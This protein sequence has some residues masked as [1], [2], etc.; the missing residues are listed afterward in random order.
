M[1]MKHRNLLW[2][3]YRIAVI[4]YRKN[5]KD[6]WPAE[7][8]QSVDTTVLD[9]PVTMHICEKSTELGGYTFREIRHL[10]K[11]GHQ[12]A[13]IAT[14]FHL[15]KAIIAGAAGARKTSSVTLYRITISIR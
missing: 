2:E 10:A 5:V 9:Q 8:F 12:T 7:D 6:K 13:I 3:E 11:D 14:H 4:T 15:D 1:K